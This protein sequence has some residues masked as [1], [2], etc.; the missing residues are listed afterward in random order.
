[1]S[2][3]MTW[4][5]RLESPAFVLRFSYS[6]LRHSLQGAQLWCPRAICLVYKQSGILINAAAY[7]SKHKGWVLF[8]GPHVLD[9]TLLD[10]AA[11]QNETSGILI[12]EIRVAQFEFL[13]ISSTVI[14][15]WVSHS[16]SRA[17]CTSASS[18]IFN[19]DTQIMC[20]RPDVCKRSD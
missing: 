9:S 15:F 19:L 2:Y 16:P 10:I 6:S 13:V 1:M 12:H 18:L 5:L 20:R 11:I 8:P 3:M 14:Y 17:C 7:H 4:G